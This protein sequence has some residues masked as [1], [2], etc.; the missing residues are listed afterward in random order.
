MG[1]AAPEGA[2]PARGRGRSYVNNEADRMRERVLAVLADEGINDAPAPRSLDEWG[3]VCVGCGADE[4]RID[5]FCSCECR[6]RHDLGAEI[7]D[8]IGKEAE[9]A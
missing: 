3:P 5:G 9:C 1:D 8:A 6:D 4:Y 2:G 7:R